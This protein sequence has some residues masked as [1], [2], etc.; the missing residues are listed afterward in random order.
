MRGRVGKRGVRTVFF[1]P[2]AV[3]LMNSPVFSIYFVVSRTK[4][5]E[6]FQL[7]RP[8]Q[9]RYA[10]MGLVLLYSIRPRDN[11]GTHKVGLQLSHFLTYLLTF[12]LRRKCPKGLPEISHRSLIPKLLPDGNCGPGLSRLHNIFQ[13]AVHGVEVRKESLR[14]LVKR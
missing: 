3:G 9:N 1:I 5:P 11:L 8:P 12:F 10:T 14:F 2:K 6:N 7:T 13:P 4:G